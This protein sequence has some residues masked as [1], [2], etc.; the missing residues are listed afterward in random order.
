MKHIKLYEEL[1][2][3]EI[4]DILDR[5]NSHGMNNLSAVDKFN[6]E[7]HDKPTKEY[8]IDYFWDFVNKADWS[9]DYDY[10]RIKKY[11]HSNYDSLEIEK[12]KIVYD[13]LYGGLYH[14][15][16]NDWLGNNGGVGIGVSDDSWSDL[17][18][19]VIGRGKDF[20]DNITATELKRM[21][22][23][24]DYRENFGYIFH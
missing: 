12:L 5:I 11:L 7:N 15:F 4:D 14:R 19:M 22:D 16:E 1:T 2:D 17:L 21:G 13:Q 9:S 6:L 10:N 8:K 23:T 18:S 20:H 3:D 24:R